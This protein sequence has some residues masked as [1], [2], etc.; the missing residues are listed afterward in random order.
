MVGPCNVATVRVS[1]TDG[2]GISEEKQVFGGSSPVNAVFTVPTGHEYDIFFVNSQPPNCILQQWTSPTGLA[3]SDNPV[4][5]AVNTNRNLTAHTVS[6]A[7]SPSPSP[8]PSPPAPSPPSPP[9]A[10]PGPCQLPPGKL[11]VLITSP[12]EGS[13]ISPT[14]SVSVTGCAQMGAQPIVDVK[15]DRRMPPGS[16]VGEG[17]KLV[18]P[19]TSNDWSTWSITLPKTANKAYTRIIARVTDAAGLRVP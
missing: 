1:Y 18:T 16:S 19:R 4:R 15:V 5:T 14:Q 9:P 2:S 17:Y 7:A 6:A 10:G 11:D 3:T 8:S 13:V 12:V